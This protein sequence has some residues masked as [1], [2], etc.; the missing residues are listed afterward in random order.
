MPTCSIPDLQSADLTC[1]PFGGAAESDEGLAFRSTAASNKRR[2]MFKR[3]VI[4][5]VLVGVAFFVTI[6]KLY[7]MAQIRG[8]IAGG[9]IQ[10]LPI[11][12]KWHQTPAEHHKG[13]NVWWLRLHP[14]DIRQ[15]G[16]H[17]A[18]VEKSQWE[19]FKVGQTIETVAIPGDKSIYLLRG[20]IYAETSHFV[21]D[22]LLL[23]AE[24]GGAAY[25]M[26]RRPAP[27]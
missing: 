25:L 21:I 17:R 5:V 19:S 15:P 7:R 16:N 23:G 10:P 3:V 13:R 9:V 12:E 8:F 22:F 27:A 11:L 24:L 6:P 26:L 1:P 14:G 2:P 18:N 20:D 4:S